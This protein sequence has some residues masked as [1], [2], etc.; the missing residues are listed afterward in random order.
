[1]VHCVR[2]WNKVRLCFSARFEDCQKVLLLRLFFWSA[3]ISVYKSCNSWQRW[4]NIFFQHVRRTS[5]ISFII[6]CWWCSVS[7]FLHQDFPGT[8]GNRL[9]HARSS[10]KIVQQSQLRNCGLC[11][12]ATVGA[13]IEFPVKIPPVPI[14]RKRIQVFET[15]FQTYSL[16]EPIAPVLCNCWLSCTSCV[17]SPVISI[18]SLK[19]LWECTSQYDL[20]FWV[21]WDLS[22]EEFSYLSEYSRKWL[23]CAVF[24]M[25]THVE[26]NDVTLLNK[27]LEVDQAPNAGM[28]WFAFWVVDTTKTN[29]PKCQIN[30]MHVNLCQV[31]NRF[32]WWL[33]DC[34]V[35]CLCHF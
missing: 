7:W 2:F 26:Q 35:F 33:G 28:L 8:T 27:W 16:Q 20:L 15:I 10:E 3:C 11:S 17:V 12:V 24:E 4:K 9:S 22:F 30:F 34:S 25:K 6:Q 18:P 23:L 29:K 14:D 5:V 19:M 32:S 1:M 31:E 13:I 21:F